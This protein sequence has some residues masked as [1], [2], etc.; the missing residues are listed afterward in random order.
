MIFDLK[1]FRK[2]YELKQLDVAK[3]F[4]CGQPNISAIEKDGKLLEDYQYKILCEKFEKNKVDE[5]FASEKLPQ[6]VNRIRDTAHSNTLNTPEA[7]TAL[8]SNITLPLERYEE[9][10]RENERLKIENESL[11]KEKGSVH[12]KDIAGDVAELKKNA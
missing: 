12:E 6:N 4:N 10:I 8:Y 2:D 11:K 7:N 1:K 3:L 5:Y 9:L